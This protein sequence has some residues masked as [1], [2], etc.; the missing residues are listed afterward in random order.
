MSGSH[1]KS[2]SQHGDLQE[3][4]A[5]TTKD[6]LANKGFIGFFDIG[7]RCFYSTIVGSVDAFV[8]QII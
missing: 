3:I 5:M 4:I 7:L 1:K 2:H 6:H 8:M